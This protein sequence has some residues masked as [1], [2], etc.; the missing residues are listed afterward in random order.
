MR[1]GR[2]NEP[3]DCYNYAKA[4]GMNPR[5]AVHRKKPREWQR[6]ADLLER[7]LA[8]GQQDKPKPRK[9]RRSLPG[10]VA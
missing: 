9:R 6:L 5:I 10:G 1:S 4:A 2:R 3:V 8:E 7:P